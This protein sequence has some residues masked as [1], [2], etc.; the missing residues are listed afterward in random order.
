MA[1]WPH[2]PR[3]LPGGRHR[4]AVPGAAYFPGRPPGGRTSAASRTPQRACGPRRPWDFAGK[5]VAV[6]GHR[7]ERRPD[8]PRHRRRGRLR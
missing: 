5:R 4:R 1:R 6:I 2:G 7:I 8:R 3:P